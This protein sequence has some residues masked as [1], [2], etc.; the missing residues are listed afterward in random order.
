MHA[1]WYQ[2]APAQP[3]PEVLQKMPKN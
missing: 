1:P 2:I 3:G